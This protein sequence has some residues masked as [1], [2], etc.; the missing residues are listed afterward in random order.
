MIVSLLQLWQQLQ[1]IN[2]YWLSIRAKATDCRLVEATESRSI[3]VWEADHKFVCTSFARILHN[4]VV[5]ASIAA[6]NTDY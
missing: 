4:K 1:I 2:S 6:T 3:K 5:F